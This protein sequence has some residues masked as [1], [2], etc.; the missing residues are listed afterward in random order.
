MRSTIFGTIRI[1]G[2]ISIAGC[3]GL[4]RSELE[5]VRRQNCTG[6]SIYRAQND[7]FCPIGT[8][9]KTP[10]LAYP[11][12]S[13][14]H[15]PR[16]TKEFFRC[17]GSSLNP[18][19]ASDG[20]QALLTDCEGSSRHG[21][22]V[23]EGKE[24]VY[25]ILLDLLNYVQKKTGRRVIITCGHRCPAHNAY[26]E[27]GKE[28]VASKH[29]IGAEVDFY[30][31]GMEDQPLEVIQL[32]M[33]YYQEDPSTQKMK[34]WADFQRYNKSESSLATLPWLNKE[35]F[36]KLHQKYEG[37]DRDNR[38]PYPYLSLQVRYDRKE[39]KPVVFSWERAHKG[40]PRR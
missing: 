17:K 15:L 31:Q 16:I 33:R 7:V 40:Y 12:E 26:A 13:E 38:H 19:I 32:L 28:G 25:P 24:G 8:P 9:E 30:V 20:E 5:K 35:I 11:W 29:Q 23:I 3:S 36:I 21:L 27:P 34:E 39:Q 1:L 2:L 18:P 14:A 22:P 37:R 6:E 10:H 4:A